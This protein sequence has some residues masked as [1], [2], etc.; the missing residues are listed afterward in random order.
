MEKLTITLEPLA[1]IACFEKIQNQLEA[2]TGVGEVAALFEKNELVIQFN[3]LETNA[4]K[5]IKFVQ[6]MGYNIAKTKID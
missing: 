6:E 5:L 1:C 4:D 3:T 2:Q